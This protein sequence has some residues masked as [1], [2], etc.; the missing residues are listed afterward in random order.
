M[1]I[2]D[3]AVTFAI[4]IHAPHEGERPA[5]DG[6]SND[7]SNFNPRSPRGG[8]TGRDESGNKGRKISIHAP[9][10]GERLCAVAVVDS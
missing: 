1:Y 2:K 4:S 8:A 3:R 9:H 6:P 10:E 5:P 7:N